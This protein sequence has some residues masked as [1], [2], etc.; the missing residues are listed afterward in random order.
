MTLLIII[1]LTALCFGLG[2]LCLWAEK[3]SH[4]WY[5]DRLLLF[6]AGFWTALGVVGVA[7]II[8]RL[9]E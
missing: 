4:K 2:F 3:K 8:V 5:S 7:G 6:V 9:L 1:L